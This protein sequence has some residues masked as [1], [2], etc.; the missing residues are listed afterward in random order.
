MENPSS[1][2]RESKS[3]SAETAGSHLHQS[4]DGRGAHL[5]LVGLKFIFMA[6]VGFGWYR[7]WIPT[8]SSWSLSPVA[9]NFI[10]IF[11]SAIPALLAPYF[12]KLIGFTHAK[13]KAIQKSASGSS[14]ELEKI[15]SSAIPSRWIQLAY[16]VP[17]FIASALGTLNTVFYYGESSTIL[18]ESIDT[19]TKAVKQI[20]VRAKEV[21]RTDEYDSL[22]KKAYELME[23]LKNEL[24]N[25]GNCGQGPEAK[26]LIQELIKIIPDFHPLSAKP[27][28]PR[29]PKCPEL[30]KS[31]IGKY[32][33]QVRVGLLASEVAKTERV[34]EVKPLANKIS[35]DVELYLNKLGAARSTV[36]GA[37]RQRAN[38][39]ASDGAVKSSPANKGSVAAKPGAGATS[40]AVFSQIDAETA[41]EDAVAWGYS[42][43]IELGNFSNKEEVFADLDAVAK[44][45]KGTRSLGSLSQVIPSL[46]S[47]LDRLTTY[48]YIF[49]ALASDIILISLYS[50]AYTN[51]IQ[52]RRLRNAREEN[53]INQL[54]VQK[55]TLIAQIAEKELEFVK[56]KTQKPSDDG[57]A[58]MQTLPSG[59]QNLD[60]G[61][62]LN[63]EQGVNGVEPIVD[64]VKSYWENVDER[65]FLQALANLRSGQFG[66]TANPEASDGGGTD[67]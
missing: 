52:R 41:I 32:E 5:V 8:V 3:S 55:A 43:A 54:S 50:M 1:A 11:L 38:T 22:S 60:E 51:W 64:G 44:M 56:L 63:D 39:E 36:N 46:L 13:R 19:A 48:I 62:A 15:E 61:M 12:A 9:T 58:S 53:L 37:V 31:D 34:S 47:R 59:D 29:D 28:S 40:T 10:S 30:I 6:V 35:K 18:L 33:Q 4:P 45:N 24:S 16:F 65:G 42:T 49:C 20:D 27:I 17:L 2:G 21:L 66:D 23:G 25:E 26:R 7:L 14:S 57:D 67:R